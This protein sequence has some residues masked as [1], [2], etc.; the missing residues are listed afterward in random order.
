VPVGMRIQFSI[1]LLTTPTYTYTMKEK[2]KYACISP[3]R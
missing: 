1:A 2:K 3:R